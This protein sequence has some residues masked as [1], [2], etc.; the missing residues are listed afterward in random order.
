MPRLYGFAAGRER[1]VVRRQVDGGDNLAD[2]DAPAL[3]RHAQKAQAAHR[4]TWET[5]DDWVAERVQ[6]FS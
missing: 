1:N 4:V 6:R 3:Q 5:L 2:L